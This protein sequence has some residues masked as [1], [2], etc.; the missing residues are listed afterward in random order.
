MKSPT[1]SSL[2]A[3]PRLLRSDDA[4]MPFAAASS[5][6]RSCFPPRATTG[7]PSAGRAVLIHELAH[8]RRRDLVGHTLGRIACAVY[9]FHPLVWTAARSLR[10]ESERACD[11][12][13]LASARGRATTPST[14]STS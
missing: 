13:A 11:D 14:C 10:A 9:W 12:L 3:A 1:G 2:D 8:V 5:R 6:R 4:K 7:A